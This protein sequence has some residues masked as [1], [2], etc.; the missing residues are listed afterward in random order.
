MALLTTQQRFEMGAE[1]MRASLCPGSIT[2]PSLSAAI[3]SADQWVE[4]NSAA[5]AAALPNPFRA[6][7]T[8]T[9]KT[10]LL[11]YVLLKRMGR[12]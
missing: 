3:D 11:M 6:N 1:F 9:E 4:D 10:M 12:I 8:P 2:K 5:Y 7:S